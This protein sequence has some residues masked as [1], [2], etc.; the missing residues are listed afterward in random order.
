M[1]YFEANVTTTIPKI[2]EM[3]NDSERDKSKQNQDKG[4]QQTIQESAGEPQSYQEN[5]AEQQQQQYGNEYGQYQALTL[6]HF[7]QRYQGQQA[8]PLQESNQRYPPDE[9]Q[10][11]PQPQQHPQYREQYQQHPILFPQEHH[12]ALDEPFVPQQHHQQHHHSGFNYPRQLQP[13]AQPQGHHQSFFQ[14]QHLDQERL[15]AVQQPQER[16]MEQIP[17]SRPLR[18]FSPQDIEILK[19]L[20]VTGEK[21]KWKQITK[22]INRASNKRN[23]RDGHIQ[24]L[25]NVSPMFVTKQY[26]NML[27]LP[28]ASYF[29]SVGSSLPY[30]VSQNGWNDLNEDQNSDSSD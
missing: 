4:M 20:L 10:Y 12:Q 21:H 17:E 30:I 11:P 5:G 14:G 6:R 26:Q 22:E 24:T 29:G 18:K 1:I 23:D 3:Y 28:N 9:Q 15:P 16:T 7:Q 19:Q 25:K 2:S 8:P 27:G 13:I